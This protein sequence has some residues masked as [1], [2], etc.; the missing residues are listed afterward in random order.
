[1]K[2]KQYPMTFICDLDLESVWLSYRF[3]TPYHRK[4]VRATSSKTDFKNI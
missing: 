3:C 1:M 4:E 2:S